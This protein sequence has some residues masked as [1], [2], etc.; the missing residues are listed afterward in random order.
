MYRIVYLFHGERD[1]VE[2]VAPTMRAAR[3]LF[4]ERYIGCD[5]PILHIV[6]VS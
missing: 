3:V 6:R 1:F 2:I 4:R 5:H